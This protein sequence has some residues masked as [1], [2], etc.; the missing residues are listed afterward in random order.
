MAR[1][2]RYNPYYNQDRMTLNTVG[3]APAV[4]NPIEFKPVEADYNILERSFAKQ[5]ERKQKAIAQQSAVQAA[6]SQVE[7]APEEDEWKQNY[8]ANINNQIQEYAN[9]GDYAGAMNMATQLAGTVSND[10]ALRGRERYNTERQEFIKQLEQKRAKG[11]ISDDS[12]ER[13]LAQNVYNYHDITDNNGNIVAGSKWEP[14]FNPRN[15]VSLNDALDWMKLHLGVSTTEIANGG[16]QSQI[17]FDSNGQRTDDINKAVSIMG[18]TTNG[19]SHTRLEEVKAEDWEKAFNAYVS[20]FPEIREDFTQLWE[21]ELWSYNKL[22]QDS[23]NDKLSE[24]QRERADL[25]AKAI[26][27]SLTDGDGG[28]LSKDAWILKRI[29]PSFDVMAYRKYTSITENGSTLFDPNATRSALAKMINYSNPELTAEEAELY[30]MSLPME[31]FLTTDI[32]RR[33][34]LINEL[35]TGLD[36]ISG[37]VIENNFSIDESKTGKVKE[38]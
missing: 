10:P 34:Q 7:L 38:H 12:Y 17:Y 36:E 16:G 25:D 20:L 32:S 30:A 22:L 18:T 13:A 23:N 9:L 21:N 37:D 27:N 29:S 33:N 5:E 14:A 2:N 6:I 19:S 11:L 35:I 3:F 24:S 1:H 26:L 15:K 8:I 28:F 31:V 4:F